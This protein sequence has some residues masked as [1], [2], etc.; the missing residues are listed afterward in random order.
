MLTIYQELDLFKASINDFIMTL[1]DEI[2]ESKRDA[3]EEFRQSINALYIDNP[4]HDP[5]IQDNIHNAISILRKE[6]EEDPNFNSFISTIDI[7][8]N[9]FLKALKFEEQRLED[10]DIMLQSEPGKT[11]VVDSTG[12]AILI[13]K[14]TQPLLITQELLATFIEGVITN[15]KQLNI[16]DLQLKN[17]VEDFKNTIQELKFVR[18]NVN[19]TGVVSSINRQINVASDTLKLKLNNITSESAASPTS[20]SRIKINN[21]HLDDTIEISKLLENTQQLFKSFSTTLNHRLLDVRQAN[22]KEKRPSVDLKIQ[23]KQLIKDLHDYIT[24]KE[25]ELDKEKHSKTYKVKTFFASVFNIPIAK[26]KVSAAKVMLQSL[27]SDDRENPH[28]VKDNFS[29]QD[30]ECLTTGNLGKL[31]EKYAATQVLPQ[32]FVRKAKDKKIAE[33]TNRLRP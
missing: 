2:K 31:I 26:N 13:K 14:D 27:G 30:M 4:V 24:T 17:A 5:V 28:P 11:R 21:L 19:Y 9:E 10:I 8:K 23:K 12:E 3:L 6:V 16:N 29:K 1:P 25:R 15:A 32:E 22:E 18:S 33:F 20:S 7:K